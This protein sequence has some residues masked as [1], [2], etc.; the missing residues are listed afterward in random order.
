MELVAPA[1]LAKVTPPSVLACHCALGVGL[2]LAVAVKD[3]AL[4]AQTDLLTGLAVTAGRVLTVTV[5]LPEPELE[6]LA[7]VTAV[8]VYVVVEA[9]LTLRVAGLAATLG[10]VKPS[11]QIRVQGPAPVRAAWMLVAPPGQMA[12]PPLT[13]AVGRARI[14]TDLLH[15][16]MQPLA[17]VSVS[18]RVNVPEAPA[19]TLTDGAVVSPLSVALPVTDQR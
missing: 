16:E 3:T 4:P 12:P 10:C 9:G 13:T 11:D 8:T 7:S 18:V 6:Q 14:V 19:L 15:V 1:M 5:A 2:P 17:L